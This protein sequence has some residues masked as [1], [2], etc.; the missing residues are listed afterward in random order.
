MAFSYHGTSVTWGRV[1][2]KSMTY[3]MCQ[4]EALG[5][6]LVLFGLLPV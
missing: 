1:G 4:N 5:E 3:G 6:F 2:S